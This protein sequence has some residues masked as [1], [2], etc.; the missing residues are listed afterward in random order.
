M[1]PACLSERENALNPAA[2]FVAFCVLI[3]LTPEH[4]EPIHELGKVIRRTSSSIRK[5][6]RESTTFSNRRATVPASLVLSRYKSI[7][8][9]SLTLSACHSR[10]QAP[11]RLSKASLDWLVWIIKRATRGLVSTHSQS[12]LP[13]LCQAVPTVGLSVMS[14]PCLL[15]LHNVAQSLWMHRS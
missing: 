9:Q 10:N 12:S 1:N 7:S 14:E 6:K 13:P 5:R 3:S 2:A 8:R 15:W 4:T 11:M